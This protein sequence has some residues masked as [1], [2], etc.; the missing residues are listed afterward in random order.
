MNNLND[1]NNYLFAA[2][3]RLNNSNLKGQE[4]EEEINRAQAVGGVAGQ[5]INNYALQLKA[6][7][8]RANIPA[9]SHQPKDGA[10]IV[11]VEDLDKP[12]VIRDKNFYKSVKNA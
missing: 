3:E 11:P 6:E 5:I 1:L 4:L 12:R 7:S 2:L 9:I 8:M 10:L